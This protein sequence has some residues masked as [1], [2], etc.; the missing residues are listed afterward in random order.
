AEAAVL[1]GM[2]KLGQ[3]LQGTGHAQALFGDS[4]RVPQHA[5]GVLGEA[6]DS[7]QSVDLR[8]V[9]HDQPM[10]FVSIELGPR[11]RYAQQFFVSA[12]SFE[13]IRHFMSSCHIASS[14]LSGAHPN[15]EIFGALTGCS[16]R[17]RAT[18]RCSSHFWRDG[19]RGSR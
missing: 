1:E 5:L 10:R 9:R 11:E 2:G 4:R 8:S 19:A 15:M 16:A 13:N 14:S 12:L 7:E 6:R 3:I 17:L 18:N